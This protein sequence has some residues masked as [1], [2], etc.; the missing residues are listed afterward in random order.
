MA[1]F[2][3][4]EAISTIRGSCLE[5]SR[6]KFF[7]ALSTVSQLLTLYRYWLELTLGSAYYAC[8]F[9]ILLIYIYD[10]WLEEV[11]AISVCPSG[12]FM[13]WG[14]Y[15]YLLKGYYRAIFAREL[16]DLLVIFQSNTSLQHL[17]IKSDYENSPQ[18]TLI[19][20]R[21]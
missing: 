3:I 2:T 11:I 8:Y 15:S 18:F 16:I 14:S 6:W 1:P 13:R 17:R 21:F 4:Y 9:S 5:E 10:Y 20:F 19:N 7:T 12:G